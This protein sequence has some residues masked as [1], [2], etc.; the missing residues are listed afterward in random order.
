[1]IIVD[2]DVPAGTSLIANP[3]ASTPGGVV[4]ASWS[5]IA[6]PTARD[7]IGLYAPGAGNTNFQSWLYVSCLQ[8]PVA[9]A[10]SGSCPYVLPNVAGTYELR[11]FSNDTYSVLATSNSIVASP[12]SLPAVS[13]SVTDGIATEGTSSDSAIFTVSRTGSTSVPLIINYATGG[14]SARTELIIR[15]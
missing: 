2:D 8:A 1:M 13:I 3:A 15:R 7:W 11:L 10:A 9:A 5:G 12:S 6:N 4:N 14:T